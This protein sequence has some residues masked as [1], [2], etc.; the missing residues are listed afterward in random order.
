[1]KKL[2]PIIFLIVAHS[3]Y[4]QNPGRTII[5]RDTSAAIIL[6]GDTI[7]QA[8]KRIGYIETADPGPPIY[9]FT[10]Y[11]IADS[12]IADF[13]ETGPVYYELTIHNGNKKEKT[14]VSVSKADD[15]AEELIRYLI[16][17]GYL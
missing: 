16:R 1:M 8:G 12:I 13:V 10:I 3:S 15:P 14:N 4:S 7:F 2:F 11:D 6:H 17:R 5:Q 9:V